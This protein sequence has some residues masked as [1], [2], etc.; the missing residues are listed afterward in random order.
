[1]IMLLLAAFYL[2]RFQPAVWHNQRQLVLLGL[3]HAGADGGRRASSCRA[4]PL[5]PYLLPLATV[6]MLVA[7]LLD[8]NLA[9]VVT[10][11]LSAC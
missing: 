11:V 7:V 3:V 8:A 5:L 10:V 2:L 6:S 9:I 1:M 4:M